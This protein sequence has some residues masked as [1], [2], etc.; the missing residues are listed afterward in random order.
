MIKI[1]P[2]TTADTRT[3]D[4]TEYQ[5][6]ES[7]IQHIRDVQKGLQFFQERLESSGVVHDYDKLTR[8]KHFY[9]DFKNN[10]ETTGWWD[11]HRKVN[12]HHLTHIDGIPEDVNLID[13]LE[14]LTDCIMAGMARQGKVN[15]IPEIE[16]AV[17]MKAYHNTVKLLMDNAEVDE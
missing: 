10:F 8:L 1:K 13:V 4:V 6:Y 9:S 16:V 17:L 12:R 14:Y 15:P 3:C 5:L 7:S 11:N 2:S